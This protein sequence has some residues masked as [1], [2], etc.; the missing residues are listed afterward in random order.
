[1]R[2]S[3]RPRITGDTGDENSRPESLLKV[4]SFLK[5]FLDIKSLKVTGRDVERTTIEK[6]LINIS[7]KVDDIAKIF[8]KKKEVDKKDKVENN[9]EVS[10]EGDKGEAQAPGQM[11]RHYAPDLPTA[12][13]TAQTLRS[14][15]DSFLSRCLISF[16]HH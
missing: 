8:T 13:T 3:D 12:M 14:L 1:M 11:T 5:R 9:Q 15:S 2:G 16:K 4:N 6:S 7:N 10:I